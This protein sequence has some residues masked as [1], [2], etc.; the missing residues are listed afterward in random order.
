MDLFMFRISGH[1]SNCTMKLIGWPICPTSGIW[2]GF[3]INIVPA[4]LALTP[5]DKHGYIQRTKFRSGFE[6]LAK[7]FNHFFGDNSKILWE[8]RTRRFRQF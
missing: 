6:V 5:F 4:I 3:P 7:R 2:A 8:S 1:F